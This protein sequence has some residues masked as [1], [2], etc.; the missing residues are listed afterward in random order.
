MDEH[1]DTA[2]VIPRSGEWPADP[3]ED[4]AID[5]HRVWIDGCFDFTHHG[6]LIRKQFSIP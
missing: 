1:D 2:E 5:R 3:Q 6:M 4:L